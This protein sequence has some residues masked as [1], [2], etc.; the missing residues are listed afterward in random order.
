MNRFE[1]LLA[2]DVRHDVGGIWMRERQ[3]RGRMEPVEPRQQL[4]LK[5]AQWAFV[6]VEDNVRGGFHGLLAMTKS[7]G[8][9][10]GASNQQREAVE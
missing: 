7:I 3:E 6:I 2:P 1:Q 9:T 4:H 5:G 10:A 8:R